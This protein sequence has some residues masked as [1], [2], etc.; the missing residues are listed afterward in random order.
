MATKDKKQ[1]VAHDDSG[2][3]ELARRFKANPFIFIGT[4]VVLIITIIAFVFVPASAPRAGAGSG[5]LSFGSYDG[6][7]ID[8]IPGNYFAQQRDYY[9]QQLRSSGSDENLQLAAF[10]VWRAAFESTVVKTAALSELK[11]AGFVTPPTLVDRKMAE[12]PQFQEN[13]RF[14]A[15]R[16]RSM[17]DADRMA[18]RSSLGEEIALNRYMEDVLSLRTSTKER[19]F[20]KAMANPERSFDYVAFPLAS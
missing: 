5:A 18:L 14:S 19:D 13:G 20:M 9:N 15:A 8:F 16:Y 1:S 2:M 10:Q 7:P 12:L 17:S 4:F 3:K 6:V 11:K